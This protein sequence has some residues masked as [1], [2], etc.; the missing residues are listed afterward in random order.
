MDVAE[1]L[2]GYNLT[3][4]GGKLEQRETETGRF[5]LRARVRRDTAPAS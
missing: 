5:N 3:S 4:S 1:N 2:Y